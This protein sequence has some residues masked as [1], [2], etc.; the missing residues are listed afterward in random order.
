MATKTEG[1]INELLR[2]K[3]QEVET[4]SNKKR[5]FFHPELKNQV[6]VSRNASIRYGRSV[7][8]SMAIHRVDDFLGALQRKFI[9]EVVK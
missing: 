8:D 1:L 3:F 2:M 4:R 6:F 5:A 7:S 9:E